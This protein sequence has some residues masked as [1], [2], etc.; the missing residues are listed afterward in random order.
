MPED[1]ELDL[2]T[3]YRDYFDENGQLIE[4][5][6]KNLDAFIYF[7]DRILPSINASLPRYNPGA[8][9]TKTLSNCFTTSDEAYAL[10]LV[11]NYCERWVRKLRA[12]QSKRAAQFQES[13][14]PSDSE[15]GEPLPHERP[16]EWF[17]ARWTGSHEG[18]QCSGWHRDGI[19]RFNEH[20]RRITI[21]RADPMEGTKLEEYI[22]DHWKGTLKD[23]KE[24]RK[25]QVVVEAYEEDPFGGNLAAV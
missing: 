17:Y 21:Q 15:E 7:V 22:K 20:A 24:K 23:R 5:R 3:N 13:S 10:A 18:N 11:E 9:K 14:M 16:A 19:E 4:E 8:R 6:K 1:F 2:I 12:K 25:K